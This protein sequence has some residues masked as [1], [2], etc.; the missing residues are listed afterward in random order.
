ML[1]VLDAE[2][3]TTA[4]ARTNAEKRVC[5][6]A[7]I[8]YALVVQ[9]MVVCG[10]DAFQ[11][12]TKSRVTASHEVGLKVVQSASRPRNERIKTMRSSEVARGTAVF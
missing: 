11:L 4:K 10:S 3:A 9:W 5:E 7:A 8:T 12:A 6:V 1:M 2:A